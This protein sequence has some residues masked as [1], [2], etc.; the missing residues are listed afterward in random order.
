M[1]ALE[2]LEV[3]PQESHHGDIGNNGLIGSKAKQGLVVQLVRTRRSHRRG[4]RFESCQDHKK[5]FL[6]IGEVFCLNLLGVAKI[7]RSG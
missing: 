1:E 6:E 5:H 7:L 2:R 4:H 3:G